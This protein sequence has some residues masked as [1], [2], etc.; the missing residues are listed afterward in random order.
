MIPSREIHLFLYLT[1]KVYITNILITITFFF[2]KVK[3][4]KCKIKK[5]RNLQMHGRCITTYSCK[6]STIDI[7]RVGRLLMD[8]H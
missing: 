8:N 4:R 1:S 7:N 2:I 6:L 3:E 5:I